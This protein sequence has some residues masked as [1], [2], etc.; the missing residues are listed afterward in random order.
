MALLLGEGNKPIPTPSGKKRR[1]YPHIVVVVLSEVTAKYPREERINPTRVMNLDPM[2]SEM[3]PAI[4]AKTAMTRGFTTINK[5]VF[6][7]S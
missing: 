3:A 2:R 4:G 7:G 5:P 1:M 6:C